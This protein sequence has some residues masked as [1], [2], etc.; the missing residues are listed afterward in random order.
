ML[1]TGQS[2][3]F[4]ILFVIKMGYISVSSS[5]SSWPVDNVSVIPVDVMK[6]FTVFFF[7]FFFFFQLCYISTL[8]SFRIWIS[9]LEPCPVPSVVHT[10]AHLCF[11]S[12]I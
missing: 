10:Y 9:K 7:F 5:I 4:C 12:A 8:S 2:E 1:K 3:L 6:L 11:R